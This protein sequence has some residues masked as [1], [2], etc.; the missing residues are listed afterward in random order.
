MRSQSSAVGS[1]FFLMALVACSGGSGP[2]ATDRAPHA[3]AAQTSI[4]A[5]VTC[6]A[7]EAGHV[8]EGPPDQR[9]ADEIGALPGGFE[10]GSDGSASYTVPLDVV[11]G[12]LGM[13][14]RLAIGYGSNGGNGPLGVGFSLGG[15]SAIARCGQNLADNGVP[16]GVTMSYLDRFCLDG[17]QLVQ[18]KGQFYGEEGAEYRTIPDSFV[19][20]VSH[21]GNPI[22]GTGYTGPEWFEVWTKDGRKLTYGQGQYARA[23]HGPMTK[24]WA[25][26][27]VEDRAGNTMEVDYDADERLGE[28]T[29]V[30]S[31]P[32]WYTADQ[33]VRGIRYGGHRNG[34]AHSRYVHFFYESRPD[35]VQRYFVGTKLDMPVRLS[36]VAMSMTTLQGTPKTA[37]VYK[38]AYENGGAGGRSKLES[39]TE[40]ES[41]EGGVCKRP[42][43]FEWHHAE[44]GFEQP[45]E[46]TALPWNDAEENELGAPRIT[47]LD[48]NGD[49]R[50]DFMFP[51][52]E[53]WSFALSAGGSEPY[54]TLTMTTQSVDGWCTGYD[55]APDGGYEDAT[56]DRDAFGWPGDYD[57]DGKMDLLPMTFSTQWTLLRSTG[58]DLVPAT[59]AFQRYV[60]RFD[61]DLRQGQVESLAIGKSWADLDGDTVADLLEC[62][63][64]DCEP[65][66]DPED[67]VSHWVVRLRNRRVS[68]DFEQTH[69]DTQGLMAPVDVP[70]LDGV[71]PDDVF[72][73][74]L[75][76]DGQQEIIAWLGDA[77]GYM[78]LQTTLGPSGTAI[79]MPTNIGGG[80]LGIP[81]EVHDHVTRFLDLNGDGLPDIIGAPVVDQP[82][83]AVPW[84]VWTN[85]GNGFAAGRPLVVGTQEALGGAIFAAP[86]MTMSITVGVDHNGD[87]REDLLVPWVAAGAWGSW[88]QE[89]V[90]TRYLLLESTG[91][92]MKV[93]DPELPVDYLPPHP[94]NSL[95]VFAARGFLRH[96]GIRVL[97]FDGDG[98]QDLLTLRMRTNPSEKVFRVHRH[99]GSSFKPDSL[100]AVTEGWREAVHPATKPT[101]LVITYTTLAERQPG[102][103]GGYTGGTCPVPVPGGVS[104]DYVCY[105]G[106]RWV[107]RMHNYDTGT[108]TGSHLAV[109]DWIDAKTLRTS[110]AWLGFAEHREAVF[111][112]GSTTPRVTTRTFYD[113]LYF[114]KAWRGA[115]VRER[116][117]YGP[118]PRSYFG[119]EGLYLHRTET[120]WVEKLTAGGKTG[121][122]FVETSRVREY[123]SYQNPSFLDTAR[124]EDLE[125]NLFPPHVDTS[126]Q[127]RGIDDYGNLL[128][129]RTTYGP[130]DRTDHRT[131][132]AQ[133][134]PSAWLIDRKTYEQ[135]SDTTP[136]GTQVRAVGY[137][138]EPGTNLLESTEVLGDEHVYLKTVLARDGFGNVTST[139]AS[140]QDGSEV[141]ATCTSYEP[142]GIYPHA[143]G[144]ALGQVSYVRLHPTL[145]VDWASVDPNGLR[146][147]TT[148]DT[149]GR[150]I[151]TQ[152]PGQKPIRTE[153]F[154]EQIGTEWRQGVRTSN[155]S[156]LVSDV[157]YD[158]L[159]RIERRSAIA[160]DGVRRQQ[161]TTYNSDG[162]VA[163]IGLPAAPGAPL[164][165]EV[166]FE[167]DARGRM[168]A[169]ESADGQRTTIDRQMGST[170]TTDPAGHVSYEMTGL[171]GLTRYVV[172]GT[173]TV[174]ESRRDFFYGPFASLR[175]TETALANGQVAATAYDTDAY[176]RV[177]KVSDPTHGDK[178]TT[179]TP[180]GEVDTS[181]DAL[182]RVVDI[183]YDSLGR[184]TG[185]LVFDKLTAEVLAQ[186]TNTFDTG[187]P[188]EPVIGRLSTSDFDDVENGTFHRVTQRYDAAGRIRLVEDRLPSDLPGQTDVIVM[189]YAWDQH[190]RIKELTYPVLPGE[191]V[192]RK[193]SFDYNAFGHLDAIGRG[194]G[195]A[196]WEAKRVDAAGRM[197]LEAHGDGTRTERTY[198]PKR[199]FLRDLS[200]T[201]GPDDAFPGRTLLA[202]HYAATPDGNLD[203]R[204]DVLRGHTESFGY[205]HLDRLRSVRLDNAV[206]PNVVYDYDRL[207]N[208]TYKTGVGN[209]IYESARPEIL[210]RVDGGQE[211]GHDVLGRQTQRPGVTTV[212]YGVFDLPLRIDG[213]TGEVARFTYGVDGRRLRKVSS[214]GTVTTV[215]RYQRTR[216]PGGLVETRLLVPEARAELRVETVNGVTT[217]K[218]TYFE[219]ADHL[220]SIQL[221]TTNV[222]APGASPQAISVEDR[223]YDAFGQ[224]RSANWAAPFPLLPE[225]VLD[226]FAGHRDDR[227]LGLVDMKGRVYDPRLGR[228]LTPDPHV[229]A[230]ERTQ[231]WARYAYVWNNPLVLTDPTGFDPTVDESLAIAEAGGGWVDGAY[232]GAMQTFT[233]GQVGGE[234]ANMSGNV[235]GY[236]PFSDYLWSFGLALYD[237]LLSALPSPEQIKH[238][239][240]GFLTG[241]VQGLFPGG[242]FLPAAPGASAEFSLGYGLGLQLGGVGA[243]GGGGGTTLGGMGVCATGVGCA[244]SP[245]AVVAGA[246]WATS[247]AAAFARGSNIAQEALKNHAFS[248]AE[249]EGAGDQLSAVDKTGYKVESVSD[250][251]IS[252]TAGDKELHG[253]MVNL[254]VIRN[255]EGKL[256][257]HL[258]GIGS[259]T[260]RAGE[261]VRTASDIAERHFGGKI[262][263]W[264]A[265]VGGSGHPRDLGSRIRGPGGIEA[266]SARLNQGSLGRFFREKYGL[267]LTLAPRYPGKPEGKVDY[268]FTPVTK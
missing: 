103:L 170:T 268:V 60:G 24:V 75:N 226:G 255:K 247:G 199:G 228:F 193:V 161:W 107:V 1:S 43:T 200:V 180:F 248:K 36:R 209:F 21:G 96:Y 263:T 50:D 18:V 61:Q 79:V 45:N 104:R 53:K 195:A 83:E 266:Q 184:P 224:A 150:P 162:T 182:G 128:D 100:V 71:M 155:E 72:T 234:T 108:P 99:R 90:V 265:Q 169:M 197:D 233:A 250:E 240:V 164:P 146:S 202:H 220:G 245:A 183:D 139:T 246:T 44:V 219:H 8:A 212:T 77:I 81:R 256:V 203:S 62:R 14:P 88:D 252:V 117:T 4:A 173:G 68:A 48:L 58:T 222:A 22:G 238:A 26:S 111:Y 229:T 260:G 93:V 166:L 213:A 135:V 11:P 232:I 243:M 2:E 201:T 149:L 262:E 31:Q 35:R 131:D 218:S 87:G 132:Y 55:I 17:K 267:D 32:V 85:T 89:L 102:S 196:L 57:L 121:F 125:S 175:R 143:L 94:D 25:L 207:G 185:V 67:G 133:N 109:H 112:D 39:I 56:C 106:N 119:D 174:D 118:H 115:T 51:D 40:C 167:Y 69:H 49:G 153:Y 15:L 171:R 237:P 223:S 6:P 140:N 134:D 27:D 34:T 258:E 97:D 148:Y 208:L 122:T 242:G 264:H 249:G 165:G 259:S 145:G 54:P 159:G 231:S 19:K 84:T 244:V 101:S 9:A 172:E 236:M 41:M 78:V 46:Q 7:Y 204:T 29:P 64:L 251:M 3:L 215:G 126:Y 13:E 105:H 76:G 211:Y 114:S 261:Y 254:W 91:D 154:K 123:E 205:D 257:G 225:T 5:A 113:N 110:K 73:L 37:R 30:S 141:R 124:P 189:G 20:V 216:R 92:E 221:V 230:P 176:G 191:S 70:W 152:H 86:S 130:E 227:E 98:Q 52:S 163:S 241:T 33:R 59:T 47:I 16:W 129:T 177:V 12:R 74:D 156:G 137:V 217:R 206:V 147:T 10:V 179:Y 192:G 66:G 210:D 158:R 127:V 194:S 151:V 187:L 82:R 142:N 160:W 80:G 28:V 63:D 239:G 214:V 186:T 198:D 157:L 23:V 38:L 42:T 190:G 136:L 65:L 168:T 116:W 144:N 235:D 95:D 188:G 178:L 120:G 181:E 138:F 253:E